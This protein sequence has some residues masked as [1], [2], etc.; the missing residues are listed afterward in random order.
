MSDN[1][2]ASKQTGYRLEYSSSNRAKCSERIL[3]GFKNQFDEADEL[4]GFEDL[5]DEDKD[6][7]RTAWAE[8]HVADEDI[9]ASARK[10][11]DEEDGKAKKKT[12]T[13]RKK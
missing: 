5:K 9:P 7:V 11:K 13:K 10:D 8:G 1:E 6:R 2:A 4:D 12:T 3:S